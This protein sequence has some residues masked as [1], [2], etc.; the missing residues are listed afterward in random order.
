[1]KRILLI[2]TMGALATV[3]SAC[4][5]ANESPNTESPSTSEPSVSSTTASTTERS[6]ALSTPTVT[7]S[8]SP[9][10]TQSTVKTATAQQAWDT[11]LKNWDNSKAYIVTVINKENDKTIN[12]SVHYPSKT[13]EGTV[14]STHGTSQIKGDDNFTYIKVDLKSMGID[15]SALP[16]DAADKWQQTPADESGADIFGVI[17][18]LRNSMPDDVKDV[19]GEANDNLTTYKSG[20]VTFTVNDQG[21]FTS[22]T[23]KENNLIFSNWGIGE[24]VE[25]P[26]VSEIFE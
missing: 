8:S 4:G 15:T 11:A 18:A 5:G 1:M 17:S 6:S 23:S 26:V 7:A 12:A 20:D 16:S 14:K 2:S 22:V 3:L 24:E 10:S 21:N 13:Y 9:E 19:K 25:M